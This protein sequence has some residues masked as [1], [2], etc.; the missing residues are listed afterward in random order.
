MPLP[1]IFQ[2]RTLIRNGLYV[3]IYAVQAV[4]IIVSPSTQFVWFSLAFLT[5][6]WLAIYFFH[7]GILNRFLPKRQFIGILL[8]AAGTVLTF[9]VTRYL[10]EEVI[11][12]ATLGIRNY[13]PSTT[14]AHYATDNLYYIAPSLVFGLL[15]KLIEDWFLHQ[16]ERAALVTEKTT[17][18]LAFLKS[19]VNPHFLFNT[20][21]NIY[22][23]AY[24]KSDEAPGAILKLSE[25][26]RYMIYDNNGGPRDERAGATHKVPLSREITHLSNFVELEKL[27]VA[28]AQVQLQTGGN[29]DLYRIEPLI[30]LAF[31]ENAFKHGDLTD[32]ANPLVIDLSVRQG[33]LIFD[34]I[35][36]KA[37]HQ[38]D[39]VGGIGLQNVRRR[40]DLLYPNQYTLRIDDT[41]DLYTCRL[42][43]SL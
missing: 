7:V 11:Y 19:Q 26:M 24:T 21:N 18:E 15:F 36:K 27:R 4:S 29:T 12:P 43:L 25:L 42:E 40:L 30:L 38:K 33:K 35:N 16:Q 8:G 28:N 23:L 41:A 31:V 34:T 1:T 14:L 37:K 22:S 3:L 20:L 13:D 10:I 32:P 5:A 17:A 6:R 2:H 39:A 9:I